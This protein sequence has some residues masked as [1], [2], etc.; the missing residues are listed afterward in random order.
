[1]QAKVPWS[2]PVHCCLSALL[3]LCL[4]FQALAWLLMASQQETKSLLGAQQ[5]HL[6]WSTL[7]WPCTVPLDAGVTA[8][9][10]GLAGL[11]WASGRPCF[12]PLDLSQPPKLTQAWPVSL[13]RSLVQVPAASLSRPALGPRLCFQ[14]QGFP[15]K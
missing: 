13:L 1:M 14:T 3:I 9:L 15:E 4:I 5:V 11:L 10:R 12:G 6:L 7:A 2:S 8:M